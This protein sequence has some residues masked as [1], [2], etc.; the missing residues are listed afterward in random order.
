MKNRKYIIESFLLFARE[1]CGVKNIL[2]NRQSKGRVE[3]VFCL[4]T[5]GM[6]Q[7]NYW[8]QNNPSGQ[9]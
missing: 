1:L 6:L 9:T 8:N 7:L 5:Q 4:K 3:C 2:I